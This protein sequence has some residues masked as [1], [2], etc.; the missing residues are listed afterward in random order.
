MMA[1]I[2]RRTLLAAITIVFISMIAYGI[3]QLPEGDIVDAYLEM[4]DQRQDAIGRTEDEMYAM[5][6]L[7]GLNRPVVVQYWDWFSGILL[8]GDFGFSYWKESDIQPVIAPLILPTIY[9]AVFTI[10]ITWIMA[11]PIGIYS[12]VRQHSI[13]DNVF[14][15]LGF[16]GLAIPDFL[17]LL[18]L[19]YVLF[20][21]FD[22]SVGGLF[23]A[24]YVSADWGPGKVW[25]MLKHLFVPG[26]VL[27]TA[28]T[29][30][31]VRIMRNNLL[32]E[33]AKPYVTTARAKGL[34]NWRVVVK[35]PVRVAINPFVSGLG[36]MLPS[37]VSGSIIVAV[38]AGLPTV[39]PILL[40]SLTYGDAELAGTI[41]LLTAIM[42]VIGTLVS[43]LLLVVVDPRIRL[44]GSG[45]T[46]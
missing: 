23:S 32:D 24:E 28:G 11:I 42:T 33:L 45:R 16:S 34:V 44:T 36:S 3:V 27:G 20:A 39:G 40:E 7:W 1:Y 38:I 19:M 4:V 37:L 17:L 9:L 41:I 18:V 29:A 35:Y 13:G 5:R 21:Y 25:D 12:A 10:A 43:D 15:L 8:R 6:E 31:L 46:G 14:T 26:V 2:V 30:G 22:Q